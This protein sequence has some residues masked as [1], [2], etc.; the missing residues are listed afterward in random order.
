MS[1]QKFPF[2]CHKR[3]TSFYLWP[4]IPSFHV[5]IFSLISNNFSLSYYNIAGVVLTTNVILEHGYSHPLSAILTLTKP[6]C[7]PQPLHISFLHSSY[8]YIYS[9]A[10]YSHCPTTT[11]RSSIHYLS[12][13]GCGAKM[14]QRDGCDTDKD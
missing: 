7:L 8:I 4:C 1:N 6:S 11:S 14:Y 9:F 13:G 3:R 2:S 12:D 5:E 10:M